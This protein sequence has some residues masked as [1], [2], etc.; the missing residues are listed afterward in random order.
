MR[1]LREGDK[2][3]AEKKPEINFGEQKKSLS[4]HP[5]GTGKRAGAIPGPWKTGEFEYASGRKDIE[6][7]AGRRGR[8]F[9]KKVSCS[10]GDTAQP[11]SAQEQKH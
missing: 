6:C 8:K 9:F 7:R 1:G 5:A 10:A 11:G 3:G 2:G 4:L